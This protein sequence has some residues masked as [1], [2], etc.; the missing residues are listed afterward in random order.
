MEYRFKEGELVFDFTG[1]GF[2]EKL[3]EKGKQ[4]PSGLKLVDFVVEEDSRTLLIE[5]KDPSHSKATPKER[6]KQAKRM[7][8]NQLINEHLVPK[9]R[10]S[11]TYLHLMKRD[12]NPFLYV[13]L[14]G[15]EQLQVEKALLVNFKEQLLRRLRQECEEPWERQ[16]INDCIVVTVED[17]DKKFKHYPIARQIEQ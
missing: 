12:N 10:G 6:K 5:V 2:V 8:N 13:V 4:A 16:Y 11:Y 1:A 17:W 7:N 3:D 15:L 14:L 9:A